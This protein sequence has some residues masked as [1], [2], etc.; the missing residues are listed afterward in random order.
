MPDAFNANTASRLTRGLL[1]TGGASGIG[2][3]LAARFA[4][5]G[6]HIAVWDLNGEGARE[7]V[8]VS[9]LS[10]TILWRFSGTCEAVWAKGG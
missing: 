8:C 4:A 6:C 7:G 2:R 10:H 1:Q 9:F 3:L 5:L